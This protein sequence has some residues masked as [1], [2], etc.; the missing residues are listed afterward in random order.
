[1]GTL[2]RGKFIA[3][4]LYLQIQEKSQLNNLSLNLKQLEKEQTKPKV[5]RRKEIIRIRAEKNETEMNKT[6]EKIKETESWL[7][8]KINKIDKP[9][10]RLTKK[11]GEEFPLWLSR[12]EFD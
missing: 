7:F 1:M 5:S 9:L 4:Q 8:V 3:I 10:A 6:I 11:N 12:N 2:L